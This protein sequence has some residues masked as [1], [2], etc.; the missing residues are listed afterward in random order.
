MGVENGGNPGSA[1]IHIVISENGGHS[2]TRLQ[3]CQKTGAG[4]GSAQST[5]CSVEATM[6]GW[7][8]D[9]VAGQDDHI[10]MQ[11]VGDFNGCR[12]WRHGVLVI[13]KIA[14]LRDGEAVESSRQ[15]GQPDFDCFQDGVV[16]L[17]NDRVFGQSQGA[18]R[19]DSGGQLK[20]S[21]SG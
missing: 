6:Q 9:E 16:R 1:R 12:Y 17:K 19:G 14:E 18:G 3:L 15:P 10:W 8:G 2:Q 7:D 4:F 5:F 21:P 13:V 11:A 20:K